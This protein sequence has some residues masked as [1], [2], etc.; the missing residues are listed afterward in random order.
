[1]ASKDFAEVSTVSQVACIGTG[2]S[3]I[4]LGATLQRWYGVD[5]IRF[6]ERH[7]SSGGTWFINSY[8]GCACDIPSALYSL[9]FAPN[10]SWTK[11]MPSGQE[12]KEYID[13]VIEE[14]K[15]NDKISFS[16]EVTRS[17]WRDDVKRWQLFVHDRITG[18]EFTHECQ[19]LF[20]ASG[21]LVEPRTFDIQGAGSFSG[22]IFHSA[23]WNHDVELEGKNVVVIGN[24]CTAAQIVPALVGRVKSLTQV[25]RSK[26]W[27]VPAA[28]FT[29]SPFLKWVFRHVP[30]SMKLHRFHIFL[31]AESD[32]SMFRMTK[33]AAQKRETRKHAAEKYIRQTAPS[34]YHDLLIPDFDY[35]CKRRVF[36]T[37]YLNSLQNEKVLLTDA[38]I[39]E[40]VPEGLM[41][42]KGLLPADVIVLATGFQTN[43][44]VP[45]M[46]V[47][48]R[49]SKSLTE[50]WLQ[51]DGP[52]AYNS[53]AVH[54]FPN[55]F[56]LLGPNSATGHTSSLMAA[57]NSV[58]YSLRV[59][60]SVFNG[61]A[62]TVEVKAKSEEDYVYQVQD[63]L[64]KRVWNAG[65]NAWYMNDKKWNSM[66]YP[67]SQAYY[68]WRSV[69]P[70]W[71][72]WKIQ[73]VKR[74]SRFSIRT[75]FAILFV[76]F[77][78]S[79][80]SMCL[81]N[82]PWRRILDWPLFKYYRDSLAALGD[83]L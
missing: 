43:K 77:L 65:C 29:Y 48:G 7:P 78:G 25:I 50:H 58:N 46:D 67:W 55:F 69:F 63:A 14:Y 41:T 82:S 80:G 45:Y 27:I 54:G 32:F 8:P 60:K 26:H 23:R 12:I 83:R 31:I 49:D 13:A 42:D 37:G 19:I 5:N 70:N 20:A 21:Q 35:G 17:I 22:D 68:W 9:S 38:K 75:I 51:Y 16:T 64:R 81:L 39:H 15:L 62:S 10:P 56:M 73:E 40:I 53:T 57:E 3:A 30:F 28:N 34:K 44:F 71:S 1:M 11:L 79:L 74:V 47:I 24:G 6:F 4:A 61:E 52:A 66:T 36:D 76:G 18:R 72:D 59:L 33:F 2:L